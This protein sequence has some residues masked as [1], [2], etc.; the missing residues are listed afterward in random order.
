[1]RLLV[2][3]IRKAKSF[4]LSKHIK[5]LKKEGS[6]G[7]EKRL[8]ALKKEVRFMRDNEGVEQEDDEV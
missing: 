3:E 1:M 5:K 4:E 6:K 2:R 8:N 7:G